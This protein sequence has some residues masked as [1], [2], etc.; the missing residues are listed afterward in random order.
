VAKLIR[1]MIVRTTAAAVCLSMVYTTSWSQYVADPD[2]VEVVEVIKSR[3]KTYHNTQ[4]SNSSPMESLFAA[5][6]F[7]E[8]I[9]ELLRLEYQSD[10][11]DIAQAAFVF[12]EKTEKSKTKEDD[13]VGLLYQ[14]YAEA[15]SGNQNLQQV[16][17]KFEPYY[18]SEDWFAAFMAHAVT[19]YRYSESLDRSASL[20]KAQKAFKV[21]P[22]NQTAKSQFAKIHIT[23]S[24]AQL[25]NL[26]FNTELALNA[27]QQY[28]ELT[29]NNFDAENTLDLLNNLLFSYSVW[30]D[31]EA[32][33]YLS[34]EILEIEKSL[35]SNTPGLTELRISK[36]KNNA[37]DFGSALE[38]AE[39]SYQKTDIDLLK[40]QA[41]RN[42][43]V[44]LAGLGRDFEAKQLIAR[45]GLPFDQAEILAASNNADLLYFGMLSALNAGDQDTALSLMNKRLD[46]TSQKL[47]TAN[48]RDT[49]SMLA[50]LENSRERQLERQ[51]AAKREAELQAQTIQKQRNLN[52]ML[53][54]LIAFLTAMVG[55]AIIFARYRDRISKELAIK[56]EEAES[57]EKMKTEFLGLV[58]HELRTPLNGIIGISDLLANHYSDPD[59]RQKSSVV[60]DSGHR[61][62]AVVEAMTDMARIDAGRMEVTPTK[63][64]LANSLPK[65][66]E[67]ARQ[68]ALAK[69]LDFTAHIDPSIATHQVDGARLEQCLGFLLSNAVKF[70]DEGRV[71]IHITAT[72]NANHAITGL[73]A[74]VADTGVGM[75]DL[76]QS[77][78]FTPFMQADQS[79][80][81]SFEGAGLSLAIARALARM[82]DGDITVNSREGRG[83]EFT[84][85]V[86]F[87][88]TKGTAVTVAEPV[89]EET[90][91]AL[92]VMVAVDDTALIDLMKPQAGEATA[93]LHEPLAPPLTAPTETQLLATES[94]SDDAL[95]GLRVLLVD[96]MESNRAIVRLLLEMKGCICFEAE[97]GA[98]ALRMLSEGPMDVVMMD[99]FMP[100]MDGVE[101]TRRIRAS[102]TRYADIPV[103]ALTADNAAETNAACMAAGVD[104][105][106]T[107]PV[108]ADE[109]TKALT[110]IINGPKRRQLLRA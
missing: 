76:V 21:V 44:A 29:E 86:N 66:V 19:S 54:V 97:D 77:R 15:L 22:N 92:P 68:K 74:I 88:D 83:S 61:L 25:H 62:L 43:A 85:T 51:A 53:M 100:K 11:S 37:M 87:A 41:I 63:I 93:P 6:P 7:L 95:V 78:L 10:D 110:Y 40:N 1:K 82:M 23:Q 20:Q 104:I 35:E 72:Y 71:H 32:L 101:A 8:D 89:I 14:T 84:M 109:L 58:S 31:H 38:F 108:K 81:R 47:L 50:A 79:M 26:Q 17:S 2:L 57:A 73:T 4:S 102:E 103:I 105:F 94:Q 48:M 27:T 36:A 9:R 70:T 67:G 80:T 46:L 75:T 39:S 49:T 34:Q 90:I 99:I 16:D 12:A 107:K 33:D 56:T 3:A 13:V 18:D 59:I 96:D 5:K 60:L 69:G 45:A 30:R 98:E 64:D 65:V 55:A 91:E 28:L 24:I 42:K 52:H 106:L